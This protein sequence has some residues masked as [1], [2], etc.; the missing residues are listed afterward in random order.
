[1]RNIGRKLIRSLKPKHGIGEFIEDTKDFLWY[2]RVSTF[3]TYKEQIQRMWFWA[4]KMRKNYDFDAL[5]VYDVIYLKLERIDHVMKNHSHLVWNSDESNNLMRKLCEAKGL[6]KR[7]SEFD[8]DTQAWIDTDD[9]FKYISWFEEGDQYTTYHSKWS[10]EPN[11]AKLFL[12]A[13]GN[14]YKQMK[15]SD[16]K[17]LFYLLDKYLEYWW[18]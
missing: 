3:H 13:R 11:R 10:V 6:A 17:R 7:I 2:N 9:R 15:E 12:K 4:W 1:M 18:D 8:Y 14:H 5:F 16:K